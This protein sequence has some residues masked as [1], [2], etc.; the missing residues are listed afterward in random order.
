MLKFQSTLSTMTLAIMALAMPGAALAADASPTWTDPAK[1]VAEN[2][3]FKVQGEYAGQG[4]GYQVIAMH[5]GKFTVVQCDGGLPGDGFTGKTTTHANVDA[6]KVKQLVGSARRV[7]RTSPT[8]GAAP[9]DGA[10]VLFDGLEKS[11]AN[12][13]KGQ[14]DGDALREGAISRKE[15]GSFKLHLEFRLPYKPA[16]QPSNQDRGNS[17]IYIHNRYETQIVDTFGLHYNPPEAAEDAWRAQFKKDFGYDARS[18]RTQWCASLYH[19]RT[20]A[21]SVCYPPLAWQTY[22][23]DFTAAKFDSSGKKTA[24]ARITVV[25]NGVKVHDDVELPKGTG[26]GGSRPEVPAGPLLL[27]GHGNPVRYRNIWVVPMD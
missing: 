26:A 19:F 17:G 12:W 11:L 22:D 10:V 21:V 6:A 7:Q 15:F 3:D 25:H 24:N 13:D 18:D 27:Q 2:A 4:V 14:L 20:P 1:A 5:E 23:I 9:P 8:M 16:R